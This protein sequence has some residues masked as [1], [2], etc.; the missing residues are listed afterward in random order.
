MEV[1]LERRHPEAATGSQHLRCRAACRSGRDQPGHGDPGCAY[2][3][4]GRAD[5]RDCARSD[6][7]QRQVRHRPRAL[8]RRQ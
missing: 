8:Y 2:R 7:D 3:A 5:D 6:A 4:E 1:V